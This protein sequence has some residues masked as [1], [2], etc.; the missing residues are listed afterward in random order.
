MKK[1]AD[2]LNQVLTDLTRKKGFAVPNM[3]PL[4]RS[5]VAVRLSIGEVPEGIRVGQ[6]FLHWGQY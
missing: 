6:S 3:L 1:A 4:K 5:K 2:L